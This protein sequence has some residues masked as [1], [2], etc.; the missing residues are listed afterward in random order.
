MSV[1]R[2]LSAAVKPSAKQSAQF[3]YSIWEHTSDLDSV[4]DLS[5]TGKTEMRFV[6]PPV[7]IYLAL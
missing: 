1:K 6:N 5:V 7:K 4:L 3:D 2:V